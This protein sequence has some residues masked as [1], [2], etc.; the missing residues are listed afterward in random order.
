MDSPEGWNVAGSPENEN[1]A[2]GRGLLTAL[3]FRISGDCE[4]RRVSP[5][6]ANGHRRKLATALLLICNVKVIHHALTLRS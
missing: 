3:G 5:L 1:P 2:L 4:N 6:V